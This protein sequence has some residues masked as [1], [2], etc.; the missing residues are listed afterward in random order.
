[1]LTAI[2]VYPK[3]SLLMNNDNLGFLCVVHFLS[4]PMIKAALDED[5][6]CDF[7]V[8]FTYFTLFQTVVN[9]ILAG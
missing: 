4:Q 2:Y 3:S 8:I 1:M 9:L 6:L 7:Y 5:S